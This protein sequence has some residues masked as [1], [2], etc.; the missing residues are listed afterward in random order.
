MTSPA[1]LLVRPAHAGDADTLRLLAALDSAAPLT[2]TVLLA[3]SDGKPVAAMSVDT[4]A[5]VADPFEPTADV[6][7]LLRVAAQP[8]LRRGHRAPLGLRVARTA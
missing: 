1:S 2:G 7:A 5:V 3:E 8:A 6:V 4:G